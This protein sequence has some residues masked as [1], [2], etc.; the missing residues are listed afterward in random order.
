LIGNNSDTYLEEVLKNKHVK[1][2]SAVE[3]V[4]KYVQRCDETSGILLG[5]TTIEGWL[6]GKSGWIYD[7][8]DKGDILSKQLYNPPDDLEKFYALN[9]A[10]QIKEIYESIL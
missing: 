6:C 9:V 7:V 10:T 1:Y 3:D 2:L 8:N 5:R 4:Q